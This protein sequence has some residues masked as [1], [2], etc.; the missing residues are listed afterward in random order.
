MLDYDFT[1]EW[2]EID[3]EIRNAKIDEVIEAEYKRDEYYDDDNDMDM[4]EDV[5][6]AQE[7][8]ELRDKVENQIKAHFPKYF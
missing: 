1:L 3:E 8:F 4:Y 2:D 6:E 5:E 7:D